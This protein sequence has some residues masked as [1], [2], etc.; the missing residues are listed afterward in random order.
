MV[1]AMMQ[2][3]ISPK[4]NV[5]SLREDLSKLYND[6]EFLACENMGEILYT[7]LKFVFKYPVRHK[8]TFAN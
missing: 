6:K 7:S 3:E 5:N 1:K 8:Y 2:D 4:A